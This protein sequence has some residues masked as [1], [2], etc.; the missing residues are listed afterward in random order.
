[1]QEFGGKCRVGKKV[2]GKQERCRVGNDGGDEVACL[3]RLQVS[4]HS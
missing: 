2:E 3:Q 4:E 1:V